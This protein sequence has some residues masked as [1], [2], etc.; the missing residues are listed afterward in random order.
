M[1]ISNSDNTVT[2]LGDGL[3][4]N[5]PYTFYIPDTDSLVVKTYNSTTFEEIVIDP[6]DYTANGVGNPAGGSIDYNPGTPINSPLSIVIT[7][8]VPLE[9]TLDLTNQSNWQPET[10]EEQLDRIV[11]MAQQLSEGLDRAVQVAQGSTTD[12]ADLIADLT[13]ASTAAVAAASAAA[14]SQTAAAASAT[15]ASASATAAAASAAA[16]ATSA[17][18]ASTAA[19]NAATSATNAANSATA[20]AAS[21]T[22]A[23]TG[24]TTATTQATAASGSATAAATSATN[25]A[26]SATAAATSATNAANSATAA[27]ASATSAAAYDL[28]AILTTRG[29]IV[30]RGAVGPQRLGLGT[31]GQALI[32]DGTD[33]VWGSVA[34]NLPVFSNLGLAAAVAGNALTISL[35]GADG[36]DPSASNPV[37]IPFRNVTLGTGTPSYLTATA[38]TSLVISSG[39]TMGFTSGQVGRL[40]IVAFNDA[41][42]LRLGAVNCLSG[43]SIMALR[44]GI[45]SSTAEGG[46][47]AADSAQVIYTGTAVTSKA[48][49][50][51]GYL[52]ATE[53]TAGTW[54]T[55]PSTLQIRTPSTPLPMDTVQIARNSTGAVATGTTQIPFDD[56]IPQNTEGDQYMSQAITPLSG[57]NLLRVFHTGF[58]SNSAAGNILQTAL[59]RDTT[60]NA[61]ASTVTQA[62]SANQPNEVVITYT[63]LASA[64]TLTTFKT[65][66]GP[67]GAITVT[68]NGASSARLYGGTMDSVLEV[69]E[70]MA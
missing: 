37:V 6:V 17:T 36:N 10:L 69:L 8:Q 44:D 38:A 23:S 40:W 41:G 66:S 27:A 3:A 31:S 33:V 47:G 67:G 13:S 63:A 1:T 62:N 35:K 16:A 51:L 5:F 42:T 56:T 59:F 18:T 24:A 61:V 45:Y 68:F 25:A 11:M 4:T 20:A 55:A 2:Y 9:Q 26:A 15:A 60:A 49:T 50:V 12:P 57:A 29:D 39:S 53:A 30:R 43:T 48:M 58:Y 54:A 19:T 46:A 52:E 70:I 64:A 22:T 7:R 21:A 32:S 34:S 65:R 28:N 14:T